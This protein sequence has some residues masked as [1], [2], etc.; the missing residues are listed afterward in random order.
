[1]LSFVCEEKR[2]V[3]MGVARRVSADVGGG[4]FRAATG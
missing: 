1:M 4:G 3:G 2:L